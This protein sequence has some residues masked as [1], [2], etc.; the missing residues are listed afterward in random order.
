MITITKT[1]EIDAA[2]TLLNHYGPCR[3]M[4][5]HHYEFI[6]SLTGKLTDEVS[7][8]IKLDGMLLDFTYLKR[9]IADTVGKWD[10][11]YLSPLSRQEVSRMLGQI[12]ETILE[13]FGLNSPERVIPFGINT[14]AENIAIVATM[15]II[16]WL[17]ENCPTVEDLYSIEVTVFETPTSSATYQAFFWGEDHA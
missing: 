17:K 5:G 15:R 4:H 3:Y 2:H 10:H 9:A 13:A 12:P 11:C 7:Q 1:Y 8:G 14:T 16:D 6:V